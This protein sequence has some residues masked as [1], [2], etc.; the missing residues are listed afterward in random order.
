MTGGQAG[1]R[2]GEV[3]IAAAVG[4]A[5]AASVSYAPVTHHA[6]ILMACG[7]VAAVLL[8]ASPTWAAV[9]LGASIPALQDLTGDRLGLHVAASDVV[10]VLFAIRLFADAAVSRNLPILRALRPVRFPVVQYA[11]VIGLLL[12]AHPGLI[13]VLKSAQRL[14]LIVLPLL[15]GAAVAFRNDHMLVL[16]VYV[17]ATTALAVIWPVLDSLGL[18]GQLQKNPTGQLIANAIL[19]LVAVRDLRPL[20]LC[21]PVLVTG[22]AL[23]ASR[24]A[25]ISLVLGIAV[26]AV[27]YR[28]H[29]LRVIVARSV[30]VVVAAIV[31]YQWLPT[32]VR[33]HV[34]NY[35]SQ[36]NTASSYPIYVREEYRHD[37]ERIIAA[38]PWTGVGVGNYLAGNFATGTS[39]EDPHNVVLLQAAEGGYVFA[40]SFFLLIAGAAFAL[41]RLRFVYL[42]PAA[43]GVLI[44][45]VMHGLVDVYWVRGT[46]VLSWL[47]VGM[48][49]G[50]AAK[51]RLESSA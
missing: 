30:L 20:V 32:E 8:F 18:Q 26:I 1:S 31:V 41:W 25:I 50:L 40:V 24:G 37:A 43:A 47:L 51:R 14:E 5:A 36:V 6:L 15:I 28:S 21:M 11:C 9:L 48:V 34:T 35:S 10:L 45:T 4:V 27:M 29:N 19:L 12:V 46:P 7:L 22:L 17:F 42:A 3:A 16:R 23:T 49:C 38:H 2:L 44:A 13:P 33:S 39:T